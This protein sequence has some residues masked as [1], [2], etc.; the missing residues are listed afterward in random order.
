MMLKGYIIAVGFTFMTG[1]ALANEAHV[2]RTP[3][4]EVTA[5]GAQLSEDSMFTCGGGVKGT[6]PQLAKEGWH[7]VQ[8]VEQ[9]DMPHPSR[10]YQQLIIQKD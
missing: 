3:A 7:I 1:N 4:S 8:A 5:P 10:S 2:C 9:S 6:I